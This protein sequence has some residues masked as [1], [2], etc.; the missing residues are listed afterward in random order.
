LINNLLV[1]CVGNICRSPMAEALFRQ[2][3]HGNGVSVSS[4]GLGA[5]VDY[6]ADDHAIDLMDARGL[7]ISGHRARQ[8]T[9][10]LVKAS[11]LIVVMESGHRRV[12]LEN[13]PAARGKVFRLGEWQDQDIPDPYRQPVEAFEESL[14]LI[15]Q[16]V[17]EWVRRITSV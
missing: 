17:V 6:P 15:E 7:D 16:G 1:V 14:E 2:H 13:E 9:P 11:D 12:I 3:L 4:A 10:E 8:L 5:L